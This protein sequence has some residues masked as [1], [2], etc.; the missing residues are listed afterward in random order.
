[1]TKAEKKA[2]EL[3]KPEVMAYMVDTKHC[4]VCRYY[5]FLGYTSGGRMCEYFYKTGK[6]R[7]GDTAHCK[8]KQNVRKK[9]GA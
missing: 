5:G 9:K 2:L 6:I 3:E 8:V 1:M 4:K 7:I